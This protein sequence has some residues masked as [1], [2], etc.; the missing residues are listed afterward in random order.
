MITPPSSASAMSPLSS[1]SSGWPKCW[2]EP[3]FDRTP[4]TVHESLT[5]KKGADA[6]IGTLVCEILANPVMR[7]SGKNSSENNP[8]PSRN[9]PSDP[10]ALGS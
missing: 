8:R 9:A 7:H 10:P 3:V 5:A 4:R 6:L 1:R 2:S